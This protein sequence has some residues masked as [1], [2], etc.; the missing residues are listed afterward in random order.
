MT[1]IGVVASHMCA[2]VHTPRIIYIKHV[3][4][5]YIQ[6][7]PHKLFKIRSKTTSSHPHNS[8]TIHV[9]TH[10]NSTTNT[11]NH[12]WSNPN[13]NNINRSNIYMVTQAHT[14]VLQISTLHG[15][16]LAVYNR[17]F[18]KMEILYS[19]DVQYS[20]TVA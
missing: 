4:I 15:L 11:E 20:S 12:V 13:T 19:C 3:K 2:H 17:T 18:H 16:L 14:C 8:H 5:F 9:H 1:S 10:R 6:I 7:T